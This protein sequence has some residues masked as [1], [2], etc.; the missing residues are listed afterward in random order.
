M[1]IEQGAEIDQRP[2]V[3]HLV[4]QGVRLRVSAHEGIASICL[5]IFLPAAFRHHPA[6]CGQYVRRRILPVK[7][8]LF[9]R[10]GAGDEQLADVLVELVRLR[11][12]PLADALCEAICQGLAVGV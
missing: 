8:L 5:R 10:D 12:E 2:R 4:L 3:V 9:E 1:V 11:T 6:A 7:K